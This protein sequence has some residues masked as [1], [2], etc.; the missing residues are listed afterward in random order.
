MKRTTARRIFRNMLA[1]YRAGYVIGRCGSEKMYVVTLLHSR[2][3]N[4]A[5]IMVD[6]TDSLSIMHI[7]DDFFEANRKAI[8]EIAEA[9]ADQFFAGAEY[10]M[11]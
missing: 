9:L 11:V 3:G 8:E 10:A 4:V 5:T 6:H 7:Q 1:L 2:F